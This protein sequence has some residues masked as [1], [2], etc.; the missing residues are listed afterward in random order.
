MRV[1]SQT[2]ISLSGLEVSPRGYPTRKQVKQTSRVCI[3]R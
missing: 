2:E 3:I 1:D